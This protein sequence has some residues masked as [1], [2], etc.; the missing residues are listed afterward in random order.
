MLA[1]GVIIGTPVVGC[2][3]AKWAGA[4]EVIG[5]GRIEMAVAG[6]AGTVEVPSRTERAEGL[7]WPHFGQRYSG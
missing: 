1:C 6:V 2:G 5:V 7:N 3:S 4:R